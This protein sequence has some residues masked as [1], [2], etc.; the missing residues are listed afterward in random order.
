MRG[1]NAIIRM[2]LERLKPAMVWLFMLDGPV[3]RRFFLDAEST[4]MLGGRPEVHVGADEVPGTLDFRFLAGL[5]VLLQGSDVD[6]LRQAYAR[7][8]DFEP[9]RIITSTGELIHEYRSAA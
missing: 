6:R 2:R 4:L 3:S 9:E 8:K 7:L 5:T 1:Q